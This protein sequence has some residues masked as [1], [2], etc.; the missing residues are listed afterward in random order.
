MQKSFPR[1]IKERDVRQDRV[2]FSFLLLS[3]YTYL[4]N[5][6]A[7]NLTLAFRYAKIF[8]SPC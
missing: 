4:Y 2:R 1:P 5:P 3:V 8:P 6:Q 7:N